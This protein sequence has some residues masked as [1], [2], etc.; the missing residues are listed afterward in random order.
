[1]DRVAMMTDGY[2]DALAELA[3]ELRLWR[4][5]LDVDDGTLASLSCTLSAE[6]HARAARFAFD[7]D[8]R[9]FVAARGWLRRLLA[10][11]LEIDAT[12]VILETDGSGKPRVAGPQ[13]RLRFNLAHTGDLAVFAVARDRELGVDLERVPGGW[14]PEQV[15]A[16]FLAAGERAA[17]AAV[18][19]PRAR[20]RVALQC[21]VG[22]EAYL[23]GTGEGLGGPVAEIDASA[24]VVDGACEIRGW[25]LSALDVGPDYVG[26][27]AVQGGLV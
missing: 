10:C 24:L 1:M 8:R 25:S 20:M 2:G 26:A 3:G 17:I 21:W 18:R 5:A 9:R 19:D 4:A 13:P 15:P 14:Y 16:R 27:M 6:E 23:K 22:K 12:A 7:R 11:C